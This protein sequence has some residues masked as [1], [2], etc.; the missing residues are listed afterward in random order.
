MPDAVP[1]AGAARPPRERRLD[2]DRAK[3]YA[4][5]LVVAGHLVANTPPEGSG[6][7]EPLR[8]ALYRFH[9]PFFLYLSGTVAVLSGVLRAQ[10]AAWPRL[11]LRRA[12]RLLLPFFGIGLL[13]LGAK[14]VAMQALVVDNPPDGLWGGLVDLLWDTSHSPATS[15]WYLLVLFLCTLAAMVLLRSGI[16]TTGLVLLGLALQFVDVPPVAYLDRFA[17]FFLFFAAGA[18][19]AERQNRLLPL[20]D[21]RQGL[22]WLLFGLALVASMSVWV[23]LP[24]YINDRW[25]LVLCGL[26]CIPAL[27]G[28]IRRPPL[29]RLGWPVTLGRY[30][31]VIYLFNTLAIGAAKAGLI[32]LGIAYTAANFPLHLATAMVA[33][34]FL[35]LLVKQLVLR[36]APLLDRLTD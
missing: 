1:A 10:S 3:G 6:W 12:E 21:R 36:R 18:W 33:G 29:S 22:W 32:R 25:S 15:V 2:L 13:I 30:A 5:L 17:R 14:L 24:W 35:P 4:I 31:M 34:V 16:G 8:Y 9:M 11:V 26:L 28:L 23:D 20:M 19:V 27:H 7:Y